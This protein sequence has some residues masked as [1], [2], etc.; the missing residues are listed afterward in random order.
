MSD[1]EEGGRQLRALAASGIDISIDDF[2]TGHSSLSY[3]HQLPIKT[4][5][6]DRSFVKRITDSHESKA[7]VRAIVAM[8][9]SLE[10]KV[11]AEGLETQEQ[12]DAVATAGCDIVQGYLFAR[13]LHPSV[14]LDL[15]KREPHC[16]LVSS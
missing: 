14:V 8:A 16:T 9:K 2:G 7:I 6:I 15:L 3:I 1:F 4:L 5:K 13:P 12:L 10:L 11:V